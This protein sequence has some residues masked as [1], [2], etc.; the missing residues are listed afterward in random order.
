MNPHFL[1]EKERLR[2]QHKKEH[3][4]RV[5]YRI[6]AVLL[7][8]RGR[9]P[10]EKLKALLLS[11]GAIRQHIQEFAPQKKLHQNRELG[12]QRR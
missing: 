6:N 9:S 12:L 11:E 8:D 10:K 5:C 3:D 7:Y 4:K 1:S 2:A